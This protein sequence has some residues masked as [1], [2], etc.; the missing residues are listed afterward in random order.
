MISK[1]RQEMRASTTTCTGKNNNVELKDPL[2]KQ[3]NFENPY[4]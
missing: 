4:Y 2:N 1:K 3:L